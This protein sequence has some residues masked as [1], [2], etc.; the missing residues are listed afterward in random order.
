MTDRELVLKE[1]RIIAS[2]SV[3]DFIKKNE[4]GEL[5]FDEEKILQSHAVKSVKV[6]YT[7][8]T[9]RV[10]H[11]HMVMHDKTHA[12]KILAESGD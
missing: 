9:G 4:H 10:R 11:F 6:V 8:S 12:F 3:G 2:A 1:A 5:C 7:A